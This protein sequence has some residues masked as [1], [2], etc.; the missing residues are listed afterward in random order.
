MK[1]VYLLVAM[2]VVASGVGWSETLVRA[3]AVA[4]TSPTVSLPVPEIFA[5]GIIS[6]PASDGSPTFLPDG[7]TLL[8]TRSAA[9][10]SVILESHKVNGVWGEPKLASFSGAWPDSSPAMAPDGTYVVFVSVRRTGVAGSKDAKQASHLWRSNRTATGWS[11]PVELPEA[12]NFC[13]NLFRPSVASDG[14]VYF[15]AAGQGKELRLFRAKFEDGAYKPAQALS[16]SDGTVKDVDPEIAPDQSFLI[17][18][19]LEADAAHEKLFVVYT[20]AGEWSKVQPI[21]YAGDE[22]NG[23]SED[24]DARLGKD[25]RTLY[26]SSDR[27]MPVHFPRTREDAEKDTKRLEDWDNG[28]ANVWSISLRSLLDGEKSEG[29]VGRRPGE[30]G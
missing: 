2:L 13:A 17:F 8:F 7:K 21:H 9:R 27:A 5:P 3:N 19:R 25:M 26:F 14:S 10:W 12:V 28:N 30:R 22:A 6:G 11:E 24:N 23:S 18:T 29:R 4:Q 20:Q 15:T 16:F 1:R